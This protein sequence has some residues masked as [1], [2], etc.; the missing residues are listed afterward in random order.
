[1]AWYMETKNVF[2][3]WSPMLSADYPPDR[4]ADGRKFEYRVRVEIAPE[5][6]GLSLPDLTEIY[7]TKAVASGDKTP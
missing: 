2:G 1:M 6:D 7:G 5:H 3:K 4:N